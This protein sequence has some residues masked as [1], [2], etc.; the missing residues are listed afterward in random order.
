M[1]SDANA[2]VGEAFASLSSSPITK[3][4]TTGRHRVAERRGRHGRNSCRQGR[5]RYSQSL[6]SLRRALAVRGIRQRATADLHDDRLAGLRNVV[7]IR[8][9]GDAAARLF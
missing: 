2:V 1:A 7:Q 6:G 8:M 5:A 4:A 3:R 9:L